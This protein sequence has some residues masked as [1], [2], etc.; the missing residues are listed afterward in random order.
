M[1]PKLNQ[2]LDEFVY[3][4]INNFIKW[5]L[6]VFFHQNPGTSDTCSSLA[7]CLGRPEEEVSLALNDLVDGKILKR[8]PRGDAE[9]FEYE[10]EADSRRLVEQFMSALDSR[11]QRLQIL[12]KLLRLG[13]RG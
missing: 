8:V 11:E 6:L 4:Q 13:A 9:I 5:D 12:T 10:P 2:E 3:Q 1:L 7:S